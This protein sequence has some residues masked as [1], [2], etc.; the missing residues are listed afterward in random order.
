MIIVICSYRAKI[1]S[2]R[3]P[4]C[5]DNTCIFILFYRITVKFYCSFVFRNGTVIPVNNPI[6]TIGVNDTAGFVICY[7]F[8]IGRD[9][10]MVV[11]NGTVVI[12]DSSVVV[13]NGTGIVVLDRSVVRNDGAMVLGAFPGSEFLQSFALTDYDTRN[14]FRPRRH[15]R[16]AED[17]AQRQ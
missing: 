5:V 2:Y 14:A 6:R 13:S 16:K 15:R 7:V 12:D 8:V 17:Q 11:G 9:G 10:S 3:S 1:I 4:V